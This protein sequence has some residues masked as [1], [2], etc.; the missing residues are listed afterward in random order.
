MADPRLFALLTEIGIIA[1]LSRSLMEAR[2]ADGVSMP[3]FALLNHLVRVGEGW[4]PQRLAR[5]FQVPK[6]SMTNT[7]SG[8]LERGLVD[9]R[10]NPA[11]GR[12]K[13]VF[14]TD[15]GRRFR[16]QAMGAVLPELQLIETQ[17]SA[18]QVEAL[19]PGLMHLRQVM[20]QARN[21]TPADP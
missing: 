6:T 3:Q 4:T 19:L 10:S 17:V 18:D 13:L 7:L 5:A 12:S 1:Q 20:D 11:D 8:L 2:L 9:V 21:A 16:E 15:A 14:L